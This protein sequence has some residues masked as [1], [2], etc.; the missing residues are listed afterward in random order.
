MHA[1]GLERGYRF[2]PADIWSQCSVPSQPAVVPAIH[3][4]PWTPECSSLNA[5]SGGALSTTDEVEEVEEEHPTRSTISA[6]IP[7]SCSLCEQAYVAH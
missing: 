6:E 7:P 2:S 5:S 4:N 3:P 1:I